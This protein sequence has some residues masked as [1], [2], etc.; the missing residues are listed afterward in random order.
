M[1]ERQPRSGD[2]FAQSGVFFLS[3]FWN[4]VDVC[5]QHENEQKKDSP[6]EGI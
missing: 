5:L 6:F 2:F 4:L 1:E 3:L